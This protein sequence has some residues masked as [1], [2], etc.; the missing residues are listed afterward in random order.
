MWADNKTLAFVRTKQL[1]EGVAK[2]EKDRI[3][4]RSEELGFKED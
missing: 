4:T 1:P 3:K 2:L